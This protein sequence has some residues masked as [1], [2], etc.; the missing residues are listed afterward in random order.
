MNSATALGTLSH[1][2]VHPYMET[3]F[4]NVP[5]WFNEGLASLYE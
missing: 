5:S 2:L 1:E 4:P 3:N